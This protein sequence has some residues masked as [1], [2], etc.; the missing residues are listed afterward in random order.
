LGTGTGYSVLDMVKSFERATGKEVKYKIAP[1][2][3][4][5]IATC[6]ADPQKAKEELGWV[7]T[8]GIDDMCKDSWSYIKGK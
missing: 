6:Y 8:R 4:G 7:A 2:R 3:P 1:R 5:D